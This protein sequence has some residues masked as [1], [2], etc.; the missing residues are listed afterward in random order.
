[1]TTKLPT[2]YAKGN[3]PSLQ[4]ELQF[5]VLENLPLIQ[6][7]DEVAWEPEAK[8]FDSVY[9]FYK[10]FETILRAHIL[11]LDTNWQKLLPLYFDV[12]KLFWFKA[13]LFGKNLSLKN[14]MT[15]LLHQYDIP[16]R[17]FDFDIPS[18]SITT[19]TSREADVEEHGLVAD[20]YINS[21]HH[22]IQDRIKFVAFTLKGTKIPKTV[23]GMSELVF[24]TV[25]KRP[26]ILQ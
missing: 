3:L 25:S 12:K 18:I 24:E 14:A 17:K 16:M 2:L 7:I 26:V 5:K 22:D 11:P 1:M 19:E 23:A 8:S 4:P 13:H 20:V 15:V 9:D 10:A 21:L 6:L